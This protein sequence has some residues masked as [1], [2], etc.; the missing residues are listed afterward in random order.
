MKLED[1]RNDFAETVGEPFQFFF[2]P[3][4][5][6]DEETELC[7]AHVINQAFPNSSKRWTIQ[8]AD[9]DN[10]YGS[11]FESSFVE[12]RRE[13]LIADYFQSR[14]TPQGIKPHLYRRKERV[15]YYLPTSQV[16]S[17][18]TEI[19]LQSGS[20][21]RRLAAKIPPTELSDTQDRDWEFVLEKDC[22][23]EALVSVLKCAHLTLFEMLGYRYALSAGGLFLGHTVLGEFFI[24]NGSCSNKEALTK[25]ASY[26]REFANLVRPILPTEQTIDDTVEGRC[27]YICDEPSRWAYLVLMRTSSLLHSALVPVLETPEAAARFVKFLGEDG[28]TLKVRKCHFDG[29]TFQASTVIEELTWPTAKFG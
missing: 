22:R 18:H 6:K 13:S 29:Q 10:F 2:C 26:F 16:P 28:S 27:L 15:D 17:N 5:L 23:L 25:A 1:L 19:I 20:E 9:V 12:L 3:L 8:R 24:Q 11:V 7:R 14:S 4:L 21:V